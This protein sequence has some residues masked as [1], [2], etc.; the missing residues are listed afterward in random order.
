MYKNYLYTHN[1]DYCYKSIKKYVD[2]QTYKKIKQIMNINVNG[3]TLN[4]DYNNNIIKYG[5]KAIQNIKNPTTLFSPMCMTNDPDIF[6]KNPIGFPINSQKIQ[7]K[8]Y[9][10]VNDNKPSCIDFYQNNLF[11]KSP[12]TSHC[13]AYVAWITQNIFGISLQPT[14]IGDWCHVAAEQYDI[15][16]S[17]KDYWNVV[18]SVQA[19][20]E[21]NNGK[22]VIAAIKIDNNDGEY[23]NNGHIAIVLPMT[24][25]IASKLQNGKNY[26][27]FMNAERNCN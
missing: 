26:Q 12:Y 7:K 14:Q 24:Y 18:N 6:Q 20:I 19:Q 10:A 2:K 9:I 4:D 5:K 15:M 16:S 13:S 22:L 11:R 23:T 3:I 1:D 21:A 8:G 17:M 27:T 25:Q